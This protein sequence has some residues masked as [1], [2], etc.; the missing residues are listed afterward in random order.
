MAE[1][2]ARRIHAVVAVT[3]ETDLVTDGTRTA[4]CLGGCAEMGLVTGTGC[5]L[6]AL[7]GALRPEYD[8]DEALEDLRMMAKQ[9]ARLSEMREVLESMLCVL[10]TPRMLSALAQL[11]L[12]TVR[13][14][15]MPSAVLN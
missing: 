4:R 13:W 9:G 11:H 3:G 1:A 15:G 8:L 14:T 12:Q 5:M 7:T 6:S 2:L 10:P